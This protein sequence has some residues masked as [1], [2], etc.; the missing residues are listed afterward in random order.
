MRKSR[1]LFVVPFVA[2]ALMAALLSPASASD[3]P[4]PPPPPPPAPY[5]CPADTDAAIQ[6]ELGSDWT[7]Q[8][9]AEFT[10][11]W[12]PRLTGLAPIVSGLPGTIAGI[13]DLDDDPSSVNVDEFINRT[14]LP[15]AIAD[16]RYHSLSLSLKQCLV[17]ELYDELAADD[18]N[19]PNPAFNDG[20]ATFDDPATNGIVPPG[21][22]EA[23][24]MHDV[25][26]LLYLFVFD[27][28]AILDLKSATSNPDPAPPVETPAVDPD[29]ALH[30]L[31]DNLKAPGV[32]PLPSVAIPPDLVGLPFVTKSAN[33]LL[34]G[35][36]N[37]VSMLFTDLG[38]VIQGLTSSVQVPEINLPTLDIGSIINTL[39]RVVDSASYSVCW[40]STKIVTRQCT[41]VDVPLGT[42]VPID[43]AGDSRFDVVA[44]LRPEPNGA[45][46]LN[47]VAMRWTV[48][49]LPNA[50]TG[51]SGP[52]QA[53]VFSFFR[54]P[55]TDILFS[56]GSS[57][58]QS[59]LARESNYLFTLA[60]VKAANDGKVLVDVDIS[61]TDPGTRSAVTYGVAPIERDPDDL[62]AGSVETWDT[63]ALDL[64]PVPA[65]PS[66]IKARLTV[67]TGD[68][69]GDDHSDDRLGVKVTMPQPDVVLKAFLFSK[70][71]VSEAAEGEEQSECCPFRDIR[72]IVDAIPTDVE[73]VVDSFPA[74][75]ITDA[76]YESSAPIEQVDFSSTLFAD[77]DESYPQ[78]SDTNTFKK[79]TAQIKEFPS[80]AHVRFTAPDPDSDAKTTVVHYDANAT[81]PHVEFTSQEAVHDLVSGSAVEQRRLKFTADNIPTV[82]DLENTTTQ[83][84][85]RNSTGEISYAA[86]G[87]V[88]NA[89]LEVADNIGASEL[90]A[91]IE[92]IPNA[93]FATY[94]LEK[95]ADLDPNKPGCEDIGHTIVHV[96]GRTAAGAPPG[97]APFGK[98]TARYRAG[99][100][101]FLTPDAAIADLEHAIINLDPRSALTCLDDTMQA[102]LRYGGLRYLDAELLENSRIYAKI[103]N[104]ADKLFVMQVARPDQTMTTRIDKLPRQ[105]TFSK[106]PAAANPHVDHNTIS[107]NGC[108]PTGLVCIPKTIDKLQVRIDGKGTTDEDD[109]RIGEFVDVTA[110]GVPHDVKVDL[111]LPQADGSKKQVSY[112][113]AT[114]TTEVTAAVAKKVADMGDL[115]IGARVEGIPTH[116]DLSFGK[117]QPTEFKAGA[118]ETIDKISAHIT[119]SGFA[120]APSS[121]VFAPHAYARYHEAFN[122]KPTLE[123]HLGLAH[124]QS[125]RMDSGGG[126]G[127]FNG[128]IRTNPPA[129]NLNSKFD[130]VADVLTLG[131]LKD[132]NC[133]PL[134]EG[135]PPEAVADP[136]LNNAQVIRTGSEAATLKPLPNIIAIKKS[137]GKTKTSCS[138]PGT[139]TSLLSIDTT[140]STQPFAINAD[141]GIGSP[142][143]VTEAL[144]EPRLTPKGVVVGDGSAPGE[145]DA[146]RLGL[147]IPV[148]PVKSVVRYGQIL[149][150]GPAPDP[151]AALGDPSF[152]ISGFGALGTL[153]I[154]VGLD[155]TPLEDRL[156]A[157]IG[158]GGISAALGFLQFFPI[159]LRDDD[160]NSASDDGLGVR[161]DYKAGNTAGPLDLDL[162]LGEKASPARIDTRIVAHTDTLPPQVKFVGKTGAAL[163]GSEQERDKVQFLLE[164]LDTAGARNASP[165]KASVKLYTPGRDGVV[166]PPAKLALDLGDVPSFV[167]FRVKKPASVKTGNPNERCGKRDSTFVLPSIVYD[168]DGMN[169]NLLDLKG[170]I[171][172]KLFTPDGEAVNP[173]DPKVFFDVVD[174]ADGLKISQEGEEG[175]IYRIL[176]PG[177]ATGKVLVKVD[178][179]DV[180]LLDLDWTGCTEPTGLIGWNSSG[181]AQVGL[182]TKLRLEIT[183]LNN[184]DLEPGFSTGVTGSFTKAAM[185]LPDPQLGVRISSNGPTDPQPNAGFKSGLHIR[186]SSKVKG[187]IPV[188]AAPDG[189][190]TFPLPIVFHVA[191]QSSGPWLSFM[192][193]IPCVVPGYQLT[194]FANIKP[195]RTKLQ[196][197]QFDVPGGTWTVT[198]DPL[199]ISAGLSGINQFFF[200]L[201]L[202]DTIAGLF[203]S[204]YDKGMQA[205]S[206][207]CKWV[208]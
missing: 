91:D 121:L 108:T 52:L 55:V 158:V 111:D 63:G 205:P 124:L 35:L 30:A 117:D 51:Y 171:D 163:P 68:F 75:R 47:S 39:R 82:I 103:R 72:A 33:D 193:P 36:V 60:D 101:A 109:F 129:T 106:E 13:V 204:P 174:M 164:F 167:D 161:V 83:V 145:E 195:H 199:G 187:T 114:K 98:L 166:S 87:S 156:Q 185:A 57:G 153:D 102:D 170:E 140:G 144:A 165:G 21:T 178:P 90:V 17:R 97:S 95:P 6:A 93:I 40:R 125:F 9:V 136:D 74:K 116:F 64:S 201:D 189:L 84:T 126:G 191:K 147:N 26:A 112:D 3:P 130:L 206:L 43:L 78:G 53:H 115:S 76:T 92:S 23:P 11:K 65:A 105:I 142:D 184:I 146:I 162:R 25:M 113:A 46:P 110:N 94:D 141:L 186:M 24:I 155:D 169:M 182:F 73:V 54:T 48:T 183:G 22:A 150:K 118:G 59:T 188:I 4:P 62:G 37:P 15:A 202:I 12:V 208:F 99:V 151:D 71:P 29:T 176:S 80:F 70:L 7:T 32:P 149:N 135:N 192:T 107:Y 197:N 198:A 137:G 45:D 5:D 200:G 38:S 160:P 100:D 96:D 104:D 10:G 67:E 2:I 131:T 181:R 18:P 143:A 179:L 88:K 122:A 120:Q 127:S 152:D 61:H 139:D 34:A 77:T 1:S 123:A 69:D 194:V 177:A 81:I 128:T 42:V 16:E 172:T 44:Q 56:V 66:S 41:P 168:S 138:D 89:H 58:F 86:N 154:V 27:N 175:K 134:M 196:L 180:T 79:V 119:N 203:T 157:I 20:S 173:N 190:H 159:Q 49:R 31:L 14:A 132:S 28:Q 148:T 19:F 207:G 50:V 85:E 133:Q 8:T